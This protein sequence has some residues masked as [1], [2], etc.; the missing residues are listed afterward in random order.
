MYGRISG[1]KMVQSF[2]LIMFLR[3]QIYFSFISLFYESLICFPPIHG[4]GKLSKF[5]PFREN[6]YRQR[7]FSPE[8][9][10][11]IAVQCEPTELH[12]Q[13]QRGFCQKTFSPTLFFQ[14]LVKVPVCKFLMTIFSFHKKSLGKFL[15]LKLAI[16]K[17][18]MT[19]VKERISQS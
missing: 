17:V 9:L 12:I 15:R 8:L 5:F 18:K 7:K 1:Y 13:S 11:Y 19:K 3:Q 6:T 10:L 4:K 16:V 14:L 2:A